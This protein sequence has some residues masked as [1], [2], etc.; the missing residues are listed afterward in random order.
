[1]KIKELKNK[2]LKLINLYCNSNN[3]EKDCKICNQFIDGDCK[4]KI[5]SIFYNIK[6]IGAK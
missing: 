3:P 6:N 1:M 2:L 4:Y 5:K